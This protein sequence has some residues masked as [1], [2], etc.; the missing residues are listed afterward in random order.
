V[1]DVHV[2]QVSRHD[3]H[4]ERRPPHFDLTIAGFYDEPFA[5]VQR[6]NLDVTPSRTA[7]RYR[8][9]RGRCRVP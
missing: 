3:A 8:V 1:L 7:R 5:G 6:T 2:A 9:K 4:V